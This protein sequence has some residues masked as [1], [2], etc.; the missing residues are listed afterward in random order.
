LACELAAFP[1]IDEHDVRLKLGSQADCF[2]FA[3]V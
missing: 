2:R 1:F 3:G